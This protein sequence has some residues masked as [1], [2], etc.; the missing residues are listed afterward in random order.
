MEKQLLNEINR[1]RE[2]MGLDI[3]ISEQDIEAED[4]VVDDGT[5]DSTEEGSTEEGGEKEEE[6]IAGIQGGIKE[7]IDVFKKI[8]PAEREEFKEAIIKGF[9]QKKTDEEIINKIIEELSKIEKLPITEAFFLGEQRYFNWKRWYK[10]TFWGIIRLFTGIRY[11]SKGRKR[12]IFGGRGIDFYLPIRRAKQGVNKELTSKEDVEIQ[13]STE[14]S[15]NELYEEWNDKFTK[16]IKSGKDIWAEAWTKTDEHH[17]EG[18]KAF[19]IAALEEFAELNRRGRRKVE[20]YVANDPL[21]I[22]TPG[23][24][25]EYPDMEFEF[26]QSDQ[27]SSDFF[28][29]NEFFVSDVFV[30]SFK[31]E[32]LDKLEARAKT[33]NV[34]EGKPAFWLKAL[35][36]ET[37]CSAIPNGKSKDGK[38]RTW[39]ELSEDRA[40]TGL[41]YILEK[42]EELNPPCQVGSNGGGLESEIE[43][44][45]DGKNVGKT[46]ED[47]E[48]DITGTSGDVW[49]D[50]KSSTNKADYEK[51]KFFKTAFNIVINSKY[52]GEKVYE[53]DIIT[54]TDDFAVRLTVPP[55]KGWGFGIDWAPWFRLPKLKWRPL[56]FI[57]KW[58]GGK[59]YNTTKCPDF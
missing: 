53:D 16:R 28:P 31:A 14:E 59:K 33:L 35:G 40:Q 15:A 7:I 36:I 1:T 43:V 18:Y 23:P 29:D 38:T 47:G 8:D 42:L 19:V 22:V 48:T 56:G 54:W 46:A 24:E 34:P 37:S 20:I 50:S 26:P 12:Y 30:K 2:I 21:K 51:H 39:K 57:A 17:P 41:E 27:P 44:N 32:I 45:S 5:E 25:I 3:L 10:K 55:R 58:F 13:H 9:K 6:A 52:I 11:I 49:G 4:I